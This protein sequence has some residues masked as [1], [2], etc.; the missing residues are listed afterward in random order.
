MQSKTNVLIFL[1]NSMCFW[2]S[3]VYFPVNSDYD[4][5]SVRVL[6]DSKREILQAGGIDS[7]VVTVL[8]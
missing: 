3:Q 2:L 5:T 7:F 4:V 8:R 6:A 1:L